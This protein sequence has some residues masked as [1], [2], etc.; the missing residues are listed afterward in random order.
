MSG[1]F[2]RSF[3][4]IRADGHRRSVAGLAIAA[5][6]L[7]VWLAWLFLARVRRYEVSEA[8]RLEV[9]Q[10][11]YRVAA[12][13]SGQ[14]AAVRLG[15]DAV[16]EVG[17]VLVELDDQPLRRELDEKRARALAAAAQIEP[18]QREIAAREQGLRE[19]EQAGRL[20]VDEAK[21][22]LR[23]ADATARFQELE[24]ARAARLRGDGILSESEAVRAAAD[25][26]MKRITAEAQLNAAART[27]AE[28]RSRGSGLRAELAGLQRQAVALEGEKDALQAATGALLG[29]IER[30]K[31]RAPIAG[32]VGE[33]TVLRAGAFLK[34]GDPIAAVVPEG[35]L[36]VVAEFPLAS[37]GRLRA[38]QPARVRLDAFPWTEYGTVRAT[39]QSI[40]T[41]AQRG[42]VR[43]EL[44]VLADP[45]SPIP[46]QHG[47]PGSVVVEL[48]SVS[49]ATLVLRAAGQLLRTG[50]EAVP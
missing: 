32:R 38:G 27:D 44:A 2:S 40:G 42:R 18:L 26:Q 24:A 43:V 3:Q 39:V 29:E 21:A 14:V 11:A 17:D 19:T 8:A 37:V 15:L 35:D 31:I 20:Q 50:G 13:V 47:L 49:P 45:T 4:A 33:I 28:R 5:A 16:V 22:R 10:T 34:E 25:A 9:G 48:E 30:R 23:E 1:S 41:E 6:L 12:P 7:G 46:M 36:R